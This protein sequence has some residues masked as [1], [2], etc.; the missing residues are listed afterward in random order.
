MMH[1]LELACAALLAACAIESPQSGPQHRDAGASITLPTGGDAPAAAADSGVLPPPP[2]RLN[3]ELIIANGCAAAPEQS[4]L[5]PS[6]LL[7]VVDRSGSMLCNPPPTTSSE[8]CELEEQRADNAIASKW[9]LTTRAM[10]TALATLPDSTFVGVS[11]FSNDARCGVSSLP[12]VPVSRNT[13]AQRSLIA[14]SFASITPSGST[15]LVGAT[16]LGY[17]YLHQAALSGQ[18]S[19]NSYVVLITDGQQSDQCSDP[20]RCNGADDCTNLLVRETALAYADG[21]NI[22]TF[23]IGVPGSERGRT[24]LSRIATAGGTAAPGCSVEMGNCHLDVTREPD[25]LTALQSAF[26][27]I[28]GETLTCELD[29]PHPDGGTVD[30]NLLNVVYTP[31]EGAARVIPQDNRACDGGAADGWQ[32][33][34]TRHQIRL[35]GRSCTTV[36][37]DR[38]ARIDVVLGCPVIGPD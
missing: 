13:P 24:V 33:D 37:G 27:R 4:S 25:L 2:T 36:R 29:L 5:T 35:C 1:A 10:V 22:K 7:F 23:V 30:L 15:P 9:E 3:P 31:H 12:N 34:S 32:Y 18:I 20:A 8:M 19:G 28:A 6:N 11:Y 38:G 26:T 14:T 21:V 17:Q 16:I